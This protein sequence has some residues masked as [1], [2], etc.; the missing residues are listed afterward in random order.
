MLPPTFYEVIDT[1]INCI[2]NTFQQKNYN[3][4]RQTIEILLLRTLREEDF[5]HELH[6]MS[7]FLSST[8]DKFK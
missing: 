5:S 3:E 7:S 8:L 6:Q 4:T 1:V 2:R